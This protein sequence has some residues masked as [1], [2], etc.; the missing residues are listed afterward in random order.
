M[1]EPQAVPAVATEFTW[2][3]LF[4][5]LKAAWTQVGL[6]NEN[7][8]LQWALLAVILL[9]GSVL[10]F[11]GI[12][13]DS[14]THLHPDERFLTM[15]EN[16][17]SWPTSL[18]QYWDTAQNPLNPYNSDNGSYVYGLFPLVMAKAA[19][20]L[21]GY[22]GYGGVYLAGRALAALMDL[23]CILLVF[24]IG[25]R[26][27]DARVGLLG[28]FLLS[29]SVLSIQNSHFFTVDSF[30]TFFITLALYMA[31]RVAQGGGWGSIIG[32]G[33]AYG[34]AVSCKINSLAFLLVITLAF[35][36]RLMNWRQPENADASNDEQAQHGKP[37]WRLVIRLEN[38]AGAP[39][40]QQNARLQPVAR[41]L[42]GM[43]V[44]I[45]VAFFTFRVAQPQA[46]NGPGF[47]GLSINTRWVGDMAMISKLVSGQIDYPPSHQWTNRPPVWYTL[48]NLILWGQGTPLGLAT[49]FGWGLMAWLL[50]R[51]RRWE[52]LL[53][54]VW[55]TFLFFYSSVQ[56][57][58]T[59]RYLLP[60][61]P[62]MALIAAF[63]LFWIVDSLHR[64]QQERQFINWQRWLP[65]GAVVLAVVVTVGTTLWALAFSSIYTRPVTRITAS[66]WMYANMPPGSA[67][68]WEE[69]DDPLP[70]SVDGKSAGVYF[71]QIK[72]T[73]YGEDTP[74]K[75]EELYTWLD[76]A[77]YIVLSSN[78]LY[79]SIP[80]LPLRYPMTTRYY[81]ALFSGELGFDLVQTFTSRPSLFGLQIVDDH[82]DE[83]FTVYDHPKVLI[84]QK[85]ASFSLENLHNL[86][87][88]IDLEHVVRMMPKDVGRAPDALMLQPETWANQQA[89]GT[90]SILYAAN[91]LLARAPTPVWLVLIYLLGFAA[92]PV[93]FI[94]LP[95][96][97]DRGYTL[98]KPL[99]VLILG[100]ASW[101][102]P[103][104]HITAFSSAL[105]ALLLAALMI[106]ALVITLR[107]L[108]EIRAFLRA[109]WR[110]I[111]ISELVF[112]VL[113]T[114][115]WLI[116]YANPD[117]WHPAMGGEKPMELAYLNAIIKSDFFPP[118][119]PWF[120]GGYIN[121]Y[122]LGWVLVGTLVKL[123]GIVPAVA[124]NLALPTWF[125]FT[126]IAAF[127]ILY[128]LAGKDEPHRWFGRP[129]CYG[130]TAVFLVLIAGNLAEIK[131]L[132]Q[133]WEALG[134]QVSVSAIPWL[135]KLAQLAVGFYAN[136][137]KQQPMPFRPE[138][139]YWNASRVM[140]NGE[141]NE[142]PFFTF[143]YG[144]LHAHLLALPYTLMALGLALNLYAGKFAGSARTLWQ[145]IK[146]WPWLNLAL[147]ALVLG[148]LWCAN[149]WDY[150]T[151]TLLAVALLGL[152]LWVTRRKLDWAFA[153]DWLGP[154]AVLL[155]LSYL[156]FYP[157]HAHYGAAYTSLE[158]WTLDRT[159][160]G[161]LLL[162]QGLPLFI[163]YTYVGKSVLGREARGALARALRILLPHRRWARARRRYSAYVRAP[164]FSYQLGWAGIGLLGMILFFS[165]LFGAWVLFVILPLAVMS[166]VLALREESRTRQRII[167]LLSLGGALLVIAVEYVVLRGDIGRMNTVFKFY[168]QTWILW[169]S[170]S[171][172]AL[173]ELLPDLAGWPRRRSTWWQ[174]ALVLLVV[175][176]A[177]YPILAIPAKLRDRWQ[178]PA[179]KGLNGA[180]YMNSASLEDQNSPID[181]AYDARGIA[182]MQQNVSGTP[183]IAE[184][185]V[186]PY[187]W[188]SRYSINT[189]LPTVIG[190]DWHQKQ[191]RAAYSS[192]VVDWRLEDLSI[193][194]NGTDIQAAW[195]VIERYNIHYIIVG[196]LEAAYY[197]AGGLAKF[198]AM[199]G[200]GLEVAYRDG[201]LTI[202]HVV[203]NG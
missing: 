196:Q 86:F 194:Y 31:V 105:I 160:L 49:W 13:W 165:L 56:F 5:W 82:A 89:S 181:L 203:G 38:S 182:W 15:V 41:A 185:S 130:L 121:Y 92:F 22:T 16:S 170:A 30:T 115:F 139:W 17:L 202:Y 67:L 93:L 76:Q 111:L 164:E 58:K 6:I 176:A 81:Q 103:S 125:A 32:L 79:E 43:L 131:L 44:V 163:L 120:A 177:S 96:W 180:A 37:R 127:G 69:W 135:Q 52:H 193:L 119:D 62:T 18:G 108:D 198:E 150:P 132:V 148:Y 188:G 51:R 29:V 65:R 136:I 128:N 19:G 68:T 73:P 184:A 183:V 142:F 186:P 47:L 97:R 109:R 168:L 106:S 11:S 172:L 178:Y 104:L 91:N 112:L 191:Q 116:R 124:F 80:R 166:A 122:Y 98:S 161:A 107:R 42:L 137:I 151:Y 84:F 114:G 153:F 54:W 24:L 83:T 85:N 110:Q 94:A 169:G 53:P 171:A 20:Q 134:S 88:G 25:R 192:A 99:G 174:A 147:L 50:V 126:G 159:S 197:S 175:G 34:M 39:A 12:N 90:W 157:F 133:G 77:Q 61:Y 179:A 173:S 129:M 100:F 140:A 145:R 162:I 45:V 187:R 63:G 33:F 189:G 200:N 144:D 48:K 10:R 74:E 158:L 102:L 141:I 72:T 149:T 70:L 3:K 143:L 59:V 146:A 87:G 7:T 155:V 9:F 113:F 21:T 23:G 154:A 2:H 95:N 117:L 55:M 4:A 156:L 71:N 36:L 138:W 64:R 78:R 195:N 8:R 66:R 26:L 190:W 40:L 14:G 118:Y 101:L 28:A 152:S 27:Y 35:S 57:V 46:F 199:L 167:S 123:T 60:I 1:V 75:R 201:P